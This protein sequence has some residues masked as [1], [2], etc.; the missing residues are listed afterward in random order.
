MLRGGKVLSIRKFL[1]DTGMN[2]KEL[3]RLTGYTRYGLYNAFK[4]IDEERQPSKQFLICMN[5]AINEKVQEEIELHEK[6]I[7]KLK[8]LQERF[9]EA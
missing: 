1:I 7:N 3:E 5:A 6:K 8:E 9:R 2:M 4:M